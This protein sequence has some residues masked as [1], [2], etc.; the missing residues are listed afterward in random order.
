MFAECRDHPPQLCN[1]EVFRYLDN[2]LLMC[3]MVDPSTSR[4]ARVARVADII[5]NYRE[6]RK[7]GYEVQ[8]EGPYPVEK[9]SKEKRAY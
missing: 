7:R 9:N 5:K 8:I 4:Y 1:K 6:K 2:S 3:E